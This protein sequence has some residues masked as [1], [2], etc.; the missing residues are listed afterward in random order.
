MRFLFLTPGTG[1]FYCGSCLRDHAL[2]TALR[3]EG[4]DVT[5]VPLY[6]P[7]ML[8]E[9]T[10]EEQQAMIQQAMAAQGIAPEPVA[11]ELPEPTAEAVARSESCHRG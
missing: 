11:P 7:L 4:H 9:P 2:A 1:H 10:E 8:E 5:V 6:L 3:R